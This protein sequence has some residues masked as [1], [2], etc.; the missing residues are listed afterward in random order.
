M[1]SEVKIK[2]SMNTDAVTNF[3]Q[4]LVESFKHGTVC[5]E[6]GMEYVTLKPGNEI[7]VEI[8]AAYK[9]DKQKLCMEFGWRQNEPTADLSDFKVSY[10]EPLVEAS[11]PEEVE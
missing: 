2:T 4:D 8:S 1:Q 10:Q 6:K 7:L 3:L 5:I 11:L 9:K